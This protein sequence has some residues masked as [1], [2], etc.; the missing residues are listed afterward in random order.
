[1][2]SEFFSGISPYYS[3]NGSKYSQQWCPWIQNPRCN[4]CYCAV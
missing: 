1:M 4:Q 3:C 2:Q